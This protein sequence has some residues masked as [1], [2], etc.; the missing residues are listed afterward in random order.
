MYLGIFAPSEASKSLSGS[1]SLSMLSD[2]SASE[3]LS[4]TSSGSVRLLAVLEKNK[5]KLHLTLIDLIFSILPAT[6]EKRIG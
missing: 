4:I 2:S 5:K 6:F 3:E 1:I